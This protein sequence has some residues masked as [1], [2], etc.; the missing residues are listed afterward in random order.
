M[1]LQAINAIAEEPYTVILAILKR[2]DTPVEILLCHAQMFPVP[3]RK[4]KAGKDT[5]NLFDFENSER[6]PV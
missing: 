5:G 4:I 3:R 1:G 6:T 2:Q